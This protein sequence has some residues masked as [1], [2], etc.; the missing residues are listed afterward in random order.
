MLCIICAFFLFTV[1]LLTLRFLEPVLYL[2]RNTVP[3]SSS[4]TCPTTSC[5]TW[6][7]STTSAS[8]TR[9]SFHASWPSSPGW[10]TETRAGARYP[11][12]RGAYRAMELKRTKTATGT[13][14]LPSSIRRRS[15]AWRKIVMEA[16]PCHWMDLMEIV[17]TLIGWEIVVIQRTQ[18][19]ANPRLSLRQLCPSTCPAA[20][21]PLRKKGLKNLDEMD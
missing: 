18:N 3:E 10:D 6:S 9:N 11:A 15:W 7:T 19:I 14:D 12:T 16:L 21:V 4:W 17:R 13:A 2:L 5:S 8:C 1:S 20:Q